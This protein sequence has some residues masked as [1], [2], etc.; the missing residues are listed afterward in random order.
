MA[1]M[2]INPKNA[3]RKKVT[4]TVSDVPTVRRDFDAITA[5]GLR[6]NQGSLERPQ[7]VGYGPFALPPVT[8]Y[9][10]TDR[11]PRAFLEVLERILY[12]IRK[13][14]SSLDVTQGKQ[15]NERVFVE[16]GDEVAAPCHASNRRAQVSYDLLRL[17][18]VVGPI[19]VIDP[20]QSHRQR[21]AAVGHRK[22]EIQDDL[23]MPLTGKAGRRIYEPINVVHEFLLSW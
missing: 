17:R 20:E 22:K 1:P 11:R 18:V 23:K 13:D 5:R 15:A 10:S 16:A 3:A 14:Q 21:H 9:P 2:P 4:P 7:H 19:P 8:G 6:G 12:A